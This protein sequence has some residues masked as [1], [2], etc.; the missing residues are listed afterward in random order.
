MSNTENV[1][2][3]IENIIERMARKLDS[4]FTDYKDPETIAVVDSIAK[5]RSSMNPTIINNNYGPQS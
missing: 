1:D 4:A 5:L 2:Q 3:T